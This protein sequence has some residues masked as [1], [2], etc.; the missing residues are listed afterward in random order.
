MIT[1]LI[2][3][4]VTLNLAILT[5]FLTEFIPQLDKDERLSFFFASI[6]IL[7]VGIILVCIVGILAYFKNLKKGW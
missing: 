3:M 6:L 2:A 5:D 4:Y 7:L 1:I